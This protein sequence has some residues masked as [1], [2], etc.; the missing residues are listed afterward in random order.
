MTQWKDA[1]RNYMKKK[2]Q[3]YCSDKLMDRLSGLNPQ[4][5]QH[6]KHRWR[7][8]EQQLQARR[9]TVRESKGRI[10][11]RHVE[12]DQ[13]R[14]R[15]HYDANIAWRIEHRQSEYLQRWVEQ[16][17]CH[18]SAD[19][20]RVETDEGKE[21][22]GAGQQHAPS[23]VVWEE[24]PVYQAQNPNEKRVTYDREKAVAYAHRW[25]NDY[26]P[27]FRSFE[28]DCTN[29]ISQCLWAG[30]AP[31]KYS[32][33]RAKG[34]WYRFE[35]VNWSFSWS[36]AHSL[37]WY[38]PNSQSGL[39][40]REVTSADQLRPGDVICYDFDG[41]GRWQHTT[42]VVAKDGAGEPLVNAHTSNSQ[43]RYWDYTDSHAWTENIK[44]KFFRIADH[45]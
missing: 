18:L 20:W 23:H 17:V 19:R 25:W 42:I 38:L 43:N 31:M 11:V 39:R 16:R 15:V 8:V 2:N 32:S 41:D 1:F 4:M 9:A 6:E 35:P 7:R 40:G 21:V 13:E 26:N 28:V 33:D 14:I 3:A 45:F 5:P 34:W 29:Y 10:R 37:R 44:Y 27:Q 30:H 12:E 22:E 24:E 36:V